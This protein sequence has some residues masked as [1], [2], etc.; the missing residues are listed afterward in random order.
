MFQSG[1]LP[2]SWKRGVVIP[3]RK[4]GKKPHLTSG[5]RPICLLSV[6]SKSFKRI[7]DRRLKQTFEM[8][9]LLSPHQIGFLSRFKSRQCLAFRCREAI[10]TLNLDLKQIHVTDE[11]SNN[12]WW[13]MSKVKIDL[14]LL[15]FS[16]AG[17]SNF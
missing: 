7:I 11:D 3:I 4:I 6:L 1:S 13:L 12:A 15:E 16:K 9:G 17:V 8:K 14:S 2:N 10:E 5:Y